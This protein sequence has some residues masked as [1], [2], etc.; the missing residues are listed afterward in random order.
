MIAV[1]SMGSRT[2]IKD[3]KARARMQQNTIAA[4]RISFLPIGPISAYASMA[5]CLS[6]GMVFFSGLKK[7]MIKPQIRNIMS[8]PIGKR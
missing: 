1:L 5:R 4:V 8:Q 6:P 7:T 3:R 2:G